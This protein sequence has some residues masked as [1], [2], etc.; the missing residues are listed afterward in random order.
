MAIIPEI[1]D[2]LGQFVNNF[3]TYMKSNIETLYPWLTPEEQESE[4]FI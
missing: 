2:K 3:F 4:A 1:A